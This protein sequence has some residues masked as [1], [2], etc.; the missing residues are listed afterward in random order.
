[1][2]KQE[3]D[4]FVDSV[5]RQI[6][7]P[8]MTWEGPEPHDFRNMKERGVRF[9]HSGGCAK[10]PEFDFAHEPPEDLDYAPDGIIRFKILVGDEEAA[11]VI[12]TA[13]R[14]AGFEPHVELRKPSVGICDGEECQTKAPAYDT[15]L[16]EVSV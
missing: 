16:F 15:V 13:I 11:A 2:T 9:V 14:T 3:F 6:G 8:K 1:M 7:Q 10:L 5:D 4:R 12:L